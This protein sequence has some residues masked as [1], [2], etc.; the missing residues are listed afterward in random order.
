MKTG[1]SIYGAH[2][3]VPDDKR[4]VSGIIRKVAG[5][6]F[7][8]ID[9]GYY[10][11]ENRKEEMAEAK[12]LAADLGLEIANYIVGNNFG[13]AIEKG[14]LAAEID[15]VKLALDEAKYFG[16]GALRVFAGGYGLDWETY[17]G[18]IA[19]ALASCVDYAEANEI[20]MAL[21]DH[22]AL[23]KNSTQQLFYL[24]K[25]ESPWLKANVDIGNYWLG[26]GEAPIE[27]V[28]AVAE[29]AVMTHIK[30]YLIIN[31]TSTSVPVG[32][33]EID[34]RECFHILSEAGYKGTLS[35]EYECN[36]GNPLFGITSSLVHIRK[37]AAGL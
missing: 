28:A 21:E 22:G 33:G 5:L 12:A 3:L 1:I 30:D 26:G 18:K 14:E 20:P 29:F 23:C 25:I 37:C 6:G 27:G 32:E 11:G 7:D 10:W 9:L 8:S 35:L 13:N 16:C 15:K 24:E 34:F 4:S 31:N 19:D 2:R 17:S 36:I